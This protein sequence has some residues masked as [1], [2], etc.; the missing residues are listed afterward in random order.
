MVEKQRKVKG[1]CLDVNQGG[2]TDWPSGHCILHLLELAEKKIPAAIKKIFNQLVKSINFIEL[3]LTSTHLLTSLCAEV[4][5]ARKALTP[6]TEGRGSS[7]G[8][9]TV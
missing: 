6:H 3:Q 1:W 5:A 4:G 7:Q 8:N 9:A 2:G